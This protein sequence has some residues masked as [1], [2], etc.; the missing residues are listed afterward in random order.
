MRKEI[1]HEKL[2]S[3]FSQN[4]CPSSKQ[5]IFSLICYQSLQMVI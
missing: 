4:G 2:K 3:K 1:D 5:Y